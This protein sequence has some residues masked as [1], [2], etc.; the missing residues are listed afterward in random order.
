VDQVDKKTIS[1]CFKLF[2]VQ[3]PG[4]WEDILETF[5]ELQTIRG[6][7]LTIASRQRRFKSVVR[8]VTQHVRYF[9]APFGL[10]RS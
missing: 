5:Q 6:T 9:E 3:A 2:K 7:G 10:V 8:K 4:E 1:D